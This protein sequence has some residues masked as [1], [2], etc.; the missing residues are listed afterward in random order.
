[1]T[2]T[3]STRL[4]MA[5]TRYGL[6]RLSRVGYALAIYPGGPVAISAAPFSDKSDWPPGHRFPRYVR[7]RLDRN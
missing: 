5:F 4:D 3:A 7:A 6:P 1:M 2:R